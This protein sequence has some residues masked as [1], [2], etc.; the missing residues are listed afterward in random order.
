MNAHQPSPPG[1]KQPPVGIDLGTTYSVLAY[2]DPTGRP[3]TVLNDQGDLLTPSAVLCDGDDIVVGR[4]AVRSSSLN[5]ELYAECFKRDM[6][7]LSF[8]QKIR[9]HDVPPEVLSAFVLD[10]L[11]RDAEQRLGPISRVVITVPAFFDATRRKATQEAGRL[12]GLEVLDLINEPTAAAVA[13]GY[14]QGFLDL[15]PSGAASAPRQVMVYDLGGGT[16]DVTILKIEG[17]QFRALAT[18]GDVRLGGKDFDQRLVD[19]L[20]EKFRAAQGVDP[21]SDPHDAAELWIEAQ[22]AKQ[23]LS[24]RSKTSVICFHAGIRMRIDVTRPE[25]EELIRDL[26]GRTETTTSLVV[27]KTGLEWPQIDRVLLIGGSSRIPL[28]REML[29]RISGK[30]PDSSQSPDEAVAHGA[31]LYAGMLMGQSSPDKSACELVNVNSHS[32]GVVGVDPKTRERLNVVLIPKDSPLPCRVVRAFKTAQADQRNVRV[33]VVEGESHRP[34]A[35]IPLGVCVVRDLPPGLPQ[36]TSIEVEYRYATNGLL[37]VSARIPSVRLSTQVEI[38]RGEA[39]DLSDLATWRK[40]LLG[41]LPAAT[42]KAFGAAAP[43][44]AVDLKD[45]ASVM[46]RLDALYLKVGQAAAGL[47]LPAPLARSQA[48]AV[49]ATGESARVRAVCAE[50]ERARQAVAN[51]ADIIRLDSQLAQAQTE[52]QKKQVRADFAQLVLGRECINAGFCP[53]GTERDLQEIRQ[54]RQHLGQ[55]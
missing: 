16:F 17:T 39:R 32:L 35:C 45:H 18:D 21:R 11:K 29:T 24:E 8:R 20:A 36:G 22:E 46:K 27:R 54:L 2:L 14:N 31:A 40:R 38:K 10:R 43:E 28:V 34:D 12:A 51:R 48:T 26:V 52:L 19:H 41:Q 30:E 1:G 47:A 25:F 44:A 5:P 6:G 42:E 15:S 4:E 13:F 55:G 49:A 53:P 7:D 50:A 37:T 3:V 33:A 9:G 23:A